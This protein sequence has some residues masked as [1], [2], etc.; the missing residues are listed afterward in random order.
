MT[1]Y[2]AGF[3]DLKRAFTIAPILGHW[4]P[5]SPI[6]LEMNASDCALAAILSTWTDGEIYPIGFMLRA[7]STVELNYDMHDKELLG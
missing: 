3:D 7:F 5:E 4:N 2:Q 6:I 1:D